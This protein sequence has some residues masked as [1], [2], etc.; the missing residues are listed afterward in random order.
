MN[1]VL[2]VREIETMSSCS[3]NTEKSI[4]MSADNPHRASMMYDG[5][6]SSRS[7][8]SQHGS[9]QGFSTKYPI[10]TLCFAK[11]SSTMPTKE[12]YSVLLSCGLG[13]TYYLVK[14]LVW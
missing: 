1:A 3:W 5:H 4:G 13:M 10:K 9:Q 11:K 14:P 8:N 2:N 6:P 7:P 12:E